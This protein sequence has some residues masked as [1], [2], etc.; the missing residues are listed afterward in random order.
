MLSRLTEFHKEP[1]G[2][3]LIEVLVATAITGLLGVGVSMAT[4]QALNIS[5]ASSNH[6]AALK[7]VENAAHWLKRDAQMAQYITPSGAAGFPVELSWVEWNN[8]THEVTYTLSSGNLMRSHSF[9]GGPETTTLI[10]Q[11]ITEDTTN[12]QYSEGVFGFEITVQ[13]NGVRPVSQTCQAQV[14]PRPAP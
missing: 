5:A 4:Y 1:A 2:F 13:L 9:N 14:I 8:D 7:Q 12:C 11:N 3:T 6:I 10:A